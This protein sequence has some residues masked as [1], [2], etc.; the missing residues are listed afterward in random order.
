MF[1]ANHSINNRSNWYDELIQMGP[2][3]PVLLAE[4]VVDLCYNYTMEASISGID[5]RLDT[6]SFWED[7]LCR[8]RL[9]WKDGKQGIH[10]FQKGDLCTLTAHEAQK[11]PPWGAGLRLLK[12]TAPKGGAAAVLGEATAHPKG[13][14]GWYFRIGCSLLKQLW[15][16]TVYSALFLGTSYILDLT[17]GWLS[18]QGAQ[19]QLSGLFLS[20]LNIV[21]F[22]LL[23]SLVSVMFGLPDILENMKAFATAACD[24]VQ[25][26]FFPRHT[27]HFKGKRGSL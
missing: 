11:L 7:F 3:P 10:Q 21:L 4:A 14:R 20:L 16:A 15:T 25:L 13:Q 9:Y 18:E 1:G 23:G 24:G 22:G 5:R 8:L 19:V 12:A 2:E 17:E 26:L 27:V 6:A